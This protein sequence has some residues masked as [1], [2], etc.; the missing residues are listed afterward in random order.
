M[1]ETA[2]DIAHFVRNVV[3]YEIN[4]VLVIVYALIAQWSLVLSVPCIAGVLMMDRLLATQLS[5]S[6]RP[7]TPGSFFSAR[8]TLVL[9]FLWLFIALTV[10]QPVPALGLVM[11]AVTLAAAWLVPGQRPQ[12]LWRGKTAMLM[13]TLANIGL[14]GFTRLT[15]DLSPEQW[16][17]LL[18]S[19][20]AASQ[21]INQGKGIVQTLAT[22][23]IWYA[24]PVGYIGW[25]I[26]EFAINQSSLVA[27]GQT[28]SDIV[29]AIRTRGG[30]VE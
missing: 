26:K 14:L 12:T 23:A 19:T 29:H 9:A 6:P 22:I 20:Q 27:P 5:L 4:G 18:G 21:T 25:A 11:W 17:K 3:M 1:E 7:A 2:G 8:V 10:P 28:M 15:A 13:Y 30:L 16:A 24:I